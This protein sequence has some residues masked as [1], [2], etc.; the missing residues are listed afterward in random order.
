M[1]GLKDFSRE[2]EALVSTEEVFKDIERHGGKRKYAHS[3]PYK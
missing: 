1:K 2:N 3:R